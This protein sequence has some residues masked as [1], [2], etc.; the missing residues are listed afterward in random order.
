MTSRP[1]LV[2]LRHRET[3]VYRTTTPSLTD[4]EREGLLSAM[5]ADGTFDARAPLGEYTVELPVAFAV[6]AEM[7][8]VQLVN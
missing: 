4:D 2:T 8:N 7:V 6:N 3:G 1:H 5:K